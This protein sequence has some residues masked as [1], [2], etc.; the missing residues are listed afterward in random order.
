MPILSHLNQ[1]AAFD[2]E[3]IETDAARVTGMVEFIQ[4]LPSIPAGQLKAILA[5]PCV[6]AGD[7]GFL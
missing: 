5:D 3:E 4:R 2:D 6:Y 7:A 1:D